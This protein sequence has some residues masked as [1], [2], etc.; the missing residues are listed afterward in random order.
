MY[1]HYL[2]LTMI[3]VVVVVV[4]V[5]VVVVPVVVVPVVV[6]SSILVV[7]TGTCTGVQLALTTNFVH[8]RCTGL[9]RECTA[10]EHHRQCTNREDHGRGPCDPRADQSHLNYDYMKNFVI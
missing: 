4:V 7:R 3:V 6:D 2:V 9:F 8:P 5:P 10:G 1:Y